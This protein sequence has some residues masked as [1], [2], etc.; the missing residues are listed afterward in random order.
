[1]KWRAI[2]VLLF[3]TYLSVSFAQCTYHAYEGF[4][5]GLNISLNNLSGGTGWQNPWFVQNSNTDVP[6]YQSNTSI[7]YSN[8]QSIGIS[9]SG[10][11]QYLK[12]GRRL[13]TQPSGPFDDYIDS[14][15]DYIGSKYGDTLWTSIVM[16]KQTSDSQEVW[17]D[18]HNDNLVWCNSCSTQHVG[19]GYFG[20]PS[21]VAGQKRW[22][23]RIGNNYYPSAI[24]V[25]I[26]SPTFFV[27]RIIFVNGNTNVSLYINPTLGN[28]APASPTISQNTSA[29]NTFRSMC[30]YL[31]ND[32][33]RG[34]IDEI[35]FAKS[36]PCVAPDPS[37]PINL[38]PTASFTTTPSTG[39][40][41]LATVLDATSS[42]DPENSNLTYL[43]N[44]GDGTPTANTITVNHTFNT[45]GEI[46]VGLTVTDASGLQHTTYKKM[47]LLDENNTFPCQST[48][49][50]INQA[51]CG[52]NNGR[53]RAQVSNATFKLVNA[54]NAILPKVNINEYHNLAPGLYTY[55]AA[56]SGNVCTDTFN[57]IVT[58]DSTTCNGWNQKMCA[59]NIG[60]NLS[61]LE[62]YAVE[63]PMRNLLKNVR[64]SLPTYSTACNCWDANVTSQMI[65]N[66]QGYP[67]HL[68][69][70]TTVG[71]TYIRMIL[72][73]EGGNM[74]VDSTYVLLYDGNATLSLQGSATQLSA[75]SGRITMKPTSKGNIYINVTFSDINDPLRNIRLL[76]IKDE[77]I[78][79]NVH[80]FY[81]EFKNKISPFKVLRFMDWA[82]TNGSPNI[83]WTDRTKSDF[84]TYSGSNGV[85]YEMIIKLANEMNKD[86][87]ICVPHQASDDYIIKMAT[88]FRDS[89]HSNLTLYVEYSNEVW[90]WIFPQAQYNDLHRPSNLN[91]GRAMAEKAGHVFEIWSTVFYDN[92]CRVKRV[93]G[94][95][96]GFNGLNEQILSQLQQDKWDYASPTFYFGLDHSN[97][98]VPRL[99]L[100]GSNATVA[101]VMTNAL[102][103]W[104]SFKT[105]VKQDYDNVKLYGKSIVGY[106]G[107]QHFVGNS[108][109]V[110][111][112]YQQAMWDAQN[113][114]QMYNMYDRVLDTIRNW[115]CEMA[116]NFSL[117]STQESVYGS[118]GVL[119][120]ID[121]VQP[122]GTT[123]RKYNALLNNIPTVSCVSNNA[124]RIWT[125]RINNLW[126]NA[127][128]WNTGSIPNAA[129]HVIIPSVSS[130]QPTVDISAFA[131]SVKVNLNA[132]LT[133]LSG[134]TL[135]ILK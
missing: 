14:N 42:S 48:F 33:N 70:T 98:G 8:L 10:G 25:S 71:P 66:A 82:R 43:W 100:L 34:A 37:V 60:T 94:L 104:S 29:S 101:D 58:I 41:P 103:S 38:P 92:P 55:T 64:S 6:G 27:L 81:P 96:A 134:A 93:L 111:Y 49:T 13:N 95:Q 127:C 131:K 108:F 115:G 129:S 89:L 39:Q 132:T 77:N 31:G 28:S 85:P 99:D 106:E 88:L 1:M 125:G 97:T 5:Y 57:L 68:P 40:I 44:F 119:S 135:R 124:T 56:G 109:G 72:S 19:A 20:A 121:V 15:S 18:F 9:G 67:T 7:N 62:D 50:N 128:N 78:D 11:R 59:M 126:S 107:G 86:V 84:F 75:A 35:R 133:I 3:S 51:S 47:T 45:L 114:T 79:V 32:E 122:Y 116:C 112:A 130:H 118:W 36:Y 117:A 80:T 26:N 90:N 61:S 21:D 52:Q 63:R 123:A 4:D 113:S 83:A 17:F 24:P 54:N 46:S 91:Y 53:I 22:T 30:L 110:P 120:D 73:S 69:Q 74:Q 16:S 12:M 65:F 105:S 76:R 23:L 87:W 2:I 102:N